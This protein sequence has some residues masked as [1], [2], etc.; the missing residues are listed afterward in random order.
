MWQEIRGDSGAVV[1]DDDFRAR[2]NV[3]KEYADVPA[4]GRELDRVREQVPDDLFE[5]GRI[6]GHWPD[7]RIDV[8]FDDDALLVGHVLDRFDGVVD[9]PRHIN[10]LDL[11]PQLARHH[12]ADTQP[13]GDQW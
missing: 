13:V 10:T 4:C 1:R 7:A 11:E 6:G 5:A 3:P 9:H 2:A 8:A 12:A